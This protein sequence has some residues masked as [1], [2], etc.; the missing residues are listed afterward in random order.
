MEARGRQK[1]VCD[2]GVVDIYI[3]SIREYMRG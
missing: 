1:G 3:W 2:G